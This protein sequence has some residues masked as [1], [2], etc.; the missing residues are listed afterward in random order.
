MK[1]C[2]KTQKLYC[3]HHSCMRIINFAVASVYLRLAQSL[4]NE[5]NE[6]SDF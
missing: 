6:T 5:N 4:L 2:V 3:Q 1:R